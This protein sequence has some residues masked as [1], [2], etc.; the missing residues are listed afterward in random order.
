MAINPVPQSTDN[1]RWYCVRTEPNREG[2]AHRHLSAW[3]EDI[4]FPVCERATVLDIT[5]PRVD[6]ETG[7]LSR[8]TVGAQRVSGPILRGYLFVRLEMS[9]AAAIEIGATNGVLR[10]YPSN[11]KPHAI[12]DEDFAAL[13]ACCDML[14]ASS[15]LEEDHK[16]MIGKTLRGT[17]GTYAGYQG[18]CSDVVKGHAILL[19]EMFKTVIPVPVPVECVE[20]DPVSVAVQETIEGMSALRYKGR[21]NTQKR[22]ALAS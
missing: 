11:T 2:V 7:R 22:G 9:E 6:P 14:A 15:I 19:L 4:Y 13:R 3:V 18:P 17:S 1:L 5:A 21:K 10:L 12:G 20:Q 8:V 16:W